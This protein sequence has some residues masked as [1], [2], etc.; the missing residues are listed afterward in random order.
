MATITDNLKKCGTAATAKVA[1]N[2]TSLNLR[3]TPST[4][5]KIVAKIPKGATV[6]ILMYSSGVSGWT[7]VKY[8]NYYGFVSSSYLSSATT[9][10]TSKSTTTTV[11]PTTITTSTTQ[12]TSNNNS[13]FSNMSDKTKKVLKI[14]GIGAAAVAAL[15]IGYKVMNNNKSKSVSGLGST[16]RKRKVL[17][18]R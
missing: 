15:A 17:H 8:G 18:L 2:S 9:S 3:E 6:S 16:R 5:A 11:T 13:I 1:T 7:A 12:T 10:T 4:S 14:V